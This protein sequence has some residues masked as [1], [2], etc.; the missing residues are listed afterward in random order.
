MKKNTLILVLHILA[1]F[2]INSQTSSS[3]SSDSFRVTL[4]DIE[5]NVFEKDS[6]ANALII[7]EYG[8]SWVSNSTYDLK[9]EQ[10]RKVKILNKDGFDEATVEIYLYKKDNN[11]Y[12]KVDKIVATTYNMENGTVVKSQLDKNNIYR[13]K[14]NENLNLVKFTLPNVKEGSV[15][16][17]SYTLTTPFMFKYRGWRFQ[18]NIPTLY[19]EYQTSIPGNWL[20]NIKLVGSK[21]LTTNTSEVKKNCLQGSR[22]ASASCSESAYAMKDIPAFIEEDYMTTEDNYLARVEYELKTFQGFDGTVRHYTKEWEDVDKEFKTDHSI[23]RQLL[24]SIKLEEILPSK[25]IELP[26]SFEKAQSIYEH[27]QKK[28]TWNG[29][30]RIFKDVSI[31]DLIKNKSGNISSINILLHNLLKES[32]YNVKPLL[33]STRQNGHATKIFPVISDF[34]YLVVHLT[35][36]EK[37]YLLDATDKYLSF[38]EIPFK[39]LNQYGRLLDLSKKGK[40]EWFDISAKKSDIIYAAD[41]HIDDN[42]KIVGNIQTKRSGYHAYRHRKAYFKNKT[43][44][45]EELENRAANAEISDYEVIKSSATGPIFRDTYNIEYENDE[46]GDNIYLDPFFIKFF[47][48]NPFKLQERSYPIDFGYKDTYNYSLKFDL[49]E[50]Y[51]LVEKPESFATSLPNKT[52]R[53]LFSCNMVQNQISLNLRIEFKEDIYPPEYYPYLK[54]FMSKIVDIQNNSLILLKKK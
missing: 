29:K 14:Y 53:L 12:E 4:P 36:D 10:K 33:I 48:E 19:S 31:K 18:D 51:E 1:F 17:Y 24:K 9:T 32:G 11:A 3:F 35:I 5:T 16:T 13:E 6:T 37:T 22:G 47:K 38:G 42:E 54:E 8:K 39:C 28:Y 50:A 25:I 44:Y 27:I 21:K 15:I 43:Q 46:T 49:G 40:S 52:G 30:Y 7:Y 20:Y 34:N 26:N 23:G 2:H 45:F 41:L